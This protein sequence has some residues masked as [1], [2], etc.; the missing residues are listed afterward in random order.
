MRIRRALIAAG[1]AGCI[2]GSG[3]A[4]APAPEAAEAALRKAVAFFREHVAVEGGYLWRYSADLQWREGEGKASATTAW[5]Q[6][7]GTPS[8]GMAFLDAYDATGDHYYLDAAKETARALVRG[9]L[10]SGGW[11]YRIEFDP[12]DRT[13]YA[14][15]VDD[16][17]GGRNVSTLDDDTT[18]AALRFLMLADKALDFEDRSIHEAVA[19]G[20]ERLMAA[21]YP[22]GAWP[23]RF[24][25]PPDPAK[26]PVKRASYPE[27][28][29]REY[30]GVDY[31]DF[32]TFNDNT[33]SDTIETFI[34][35]H[36]VYGSSSPVE[37]GRGDVYRAAA[38]R[39][40]DFI[41]LAQMPDPQPAWAQQ[42]NHDMHPAWARKFE[43]PAVTGGESQGV[44]RTLLFLY[45]K[46][47]NQKYL[48]PVPRA[49]A[50][51]K[52]SRLPDGRIPRFLELQ[53]N[54][55][56]YFTM[57]YQLTY[58]SDDMPTHYSFIGGSRLDQIEAEYKK[59]I[60][61]EPEQE[62]NK[63]A[64]S[65]EQVRA[66][67]DALDERGAWVESGRLR[68]HE[69]NPTDRVID[70]ATFSTNVRVLADYLMRRE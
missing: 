21:Q 40:G 55:P 34:L 2:S 8:V 37:G 14:Y 1:L 63:P 62:A 57:D 11:E 59:L 50:Y 52:S 45:R 20:L 61:G 29:S 3:L 35:A 64:V 48:E 23:Q 9:Q 6:P 41:L 5:V 27:T 4:Q 70:S 30:P 39:G 15:R 38:E 32:Y 19:F 10:R 24:E 25:A 18:Q 47:A 17:E 67:I 46:T 28:W 12:K 44:L 26:Y 22:N 65:E 16:H 58:S 43:P 68:Y 66:V 13:R 33:I 60:S 36:E 7:P 53:T 51:L 31:K 69:D 49:L 56:L 42:Y 54:R